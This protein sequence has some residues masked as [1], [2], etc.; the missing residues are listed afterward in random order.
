MAVQ[1]K[2]TVDQSLDYRYMPTEYGDYVQWLD[3]LAN[4]KLTEQDI[5]G[6]L[7]NSLYRISHLYHIID[8][9]G[10]HVRFVL[11]P[12][13]FD[14][15]WDQTNRNCILKSRQHGY[16]TMIG[17][18]ILDTALFNRNITAGIIAHKLDDAKS[19]FARKYYYPYQHLPRM[20]RESNPI[21]R[22]MQDRVQWFNGSK[23]QVSTSARSDTMQ[24]LHVSEYGY[25]SLH[26]PM[27]AAEIR[28]GSFPAVPTSGQ[29]WVESTMEGS[30][31]EFAN[32][33]TS[34]KARRDQGKA[35]SQLDFSFHFAAWWED[36]D[37]RMDPEG[38]IFTTY[39]DEYFNG[40]ELSGVY[41]DDEQRAW[42]VSTRDSLGNDNKSMA[43]DGN[44]E[45]NIMGEERMFQQ[46]PSIPEEAMQAS[47]KGGFLTKEM[48][49][50]RGEQRIG[51]FPYN[52]AWP[53]YTGWDLGLDDQMAIWVFQAYGSARYLIAYYENSGE[54]YP[55]YVKWL[56]ETKEH[57]DWVFAGHYIPHDGKNRSA[58]DDQTRNPKQALMDLGLRNINI[59]T[60]PRDQHAKTNRVTKMRDWINMSFID[61]RGC[62]RGIACLDNYRKRPDKVNGGYTNVAV[63]NWAIHGADAL[64]T[65]SWGFNSGFVRSI[66]DLLPDVA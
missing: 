46:H 65:A 13:Q 1:A 37:N 58:V 22:E 57:K 39:D 5:R 54:S 4:T 18:Y 2:K 55:H 63:R 41:T 8:K 34:S 36:P 24:L 51:N 40:L 29:I 42:Y 60:R 12:V 59:V 33:C 26:D 53:C 56:K 38:V 61:E 17:I 44:D 50:A 25:T 14:F 9:Q 32:L 45:E 66:E 23:I 15:Y 43:T 48:A 19:I 31:G 35:V 20:I 21:V 27:K 30:G 52:P 6:L 16:T 49:I 7:T 10:R 47:V 3:H 28:A 64:M 62:S 11:K